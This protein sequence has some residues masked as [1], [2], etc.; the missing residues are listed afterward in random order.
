MK[1]ILLEPQSNTFFRNENKLYF[2]RS[3]LEYLQQKI[4]AV[5]SFQKGEWFTDSTIGIP[6]VPDFDLTKQDHRA[7]LTATIQEKLM[8]IDEI[9]SLVSF[10]TD[11]NKHE[12]KFYVSFIVKTTYGEELNYSTS[13]DM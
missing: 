11:Y 12:R 1:D 9:E 5:L 4:R 10:E 13:I 2:T 3:K 8:E 7:L 6:Y